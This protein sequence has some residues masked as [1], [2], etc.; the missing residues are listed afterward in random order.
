LTSPGLLNY[1]CYV[2][3]EADLNV[4]E[5][6]FFE[7]FEFLF[8]CSWMSSGILM[9]KLMGYL[10]TYKALDLCTFFLLFALRKFWTTFLFSFLYSFN[11]IFNSGARCLLLVCRLKRSPW[12]LKRM[13]NRTQSCLREFVDCKPAISEILED[14]QWMC[15]ANS[16]FGMRF[17]L[18]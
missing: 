15:K 2:S 11:F 4:C 3:R 9:T 5:G 10:S 16:E 13:N 17:S 14:I 7:N 6:I 12:S 1:K 18:C 8:Q